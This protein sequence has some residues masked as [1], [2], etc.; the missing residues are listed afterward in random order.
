MKGMPTNNQKNLKGREHLPS[1]VQHRDPSCFD[2][3]LQIKEEIRDTF[4]SAT[5]I[6]NRATVSTS[7]KTSSAGGSSSTAMKS[8]LHFALKRTRYIN[9]TEYYLQIIIYI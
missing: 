1:E 7:T 9:Y 3:V 5:T 4:R 6:E 8:V 2:H